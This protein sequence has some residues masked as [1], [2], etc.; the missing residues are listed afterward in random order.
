MAGHGADVDIDA[1]GG[2]VAAL[3]MGKDAN[4]PGI[5]QAILALGLAHAHRQAIFRRQS[6]DEQGTQPVEGG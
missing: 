6:L 2:Q 1:L 4:L 3:G 5:D